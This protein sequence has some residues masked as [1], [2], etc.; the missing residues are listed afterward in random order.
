VG[1][2]LTVPC[3]GTASGSREEGSGWRLCQTADFSDGDTELPNPSTTG[4]GR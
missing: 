2:I 3:T 1:I 4:A